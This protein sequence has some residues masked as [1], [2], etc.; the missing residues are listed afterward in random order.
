MDPYAALLY[1]GNRAF[2]FNID[3]YLVERMDESFKSL[4][5]SHEA[6]K[7]Q[8]D[9]ILVRVGMEQS[10][11]LNPVVKGQRIEEEGQ[12]TGVSDN[13]FAGEEGKA[14]EAVG[15]VSAASRR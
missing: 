14:T 12:R 9:E 11:A 8:N 4:L 5:R 15:L 7:A 3:L 10:A 13:Y 2:G 1:Q 6:L